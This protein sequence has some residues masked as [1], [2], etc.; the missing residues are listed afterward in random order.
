MAR[1]IDYMYAPSRGR[2]MMQC[3][4]DCRIAI[5]HFVPIVGLGFYGLLPEYVHDAFNVLIKHSENMYYRLMPT[6]QVSE[7]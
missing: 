7:E 6:N 5:A 1:E 3:K 2:N 4:F